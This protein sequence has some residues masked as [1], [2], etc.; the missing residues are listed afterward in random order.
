VL[1]CDPDEAEE[2]LSEFL[3]RLEDRD[4]PIT[5]FDDVEEV[6][7]EARHVVDPEEE[8]PAVS[9]AAAVTVYLAHRRTELDDEPEDIL[10]LAARA[11]FDGTPPPDVA[12]WLAARG[13]DL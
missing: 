12:D 10:R 1:V 3:T 11:E 6:V 7:A 4:E 5:S 9:M 13:V 2:G 8:L